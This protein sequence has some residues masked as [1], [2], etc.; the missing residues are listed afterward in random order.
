MEEYRLK[1]SVLNRGTRQNRKV[2]IPYRIKA[3]SILNG[4]AYRVDMLDG[5]G[6]WVL[7]PGMIEELYEKVGENG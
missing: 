6:L 4:T 3:Q 2:G 5:E 7:P 1:Q